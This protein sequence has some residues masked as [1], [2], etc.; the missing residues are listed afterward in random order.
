MIAAILFTISIATFCQFGIYY[1]RAS[2]RATAETPVSDRLKFAAGISTSSLGPRD[3]QSILKVHDLTPA[4]SGS[5]GTF[6]AIR[7][8]YRVVESLGRIIPSIT[9][10]AEAEMTVCTRY[11][12]VLVDQRLERNIACA[13]HVR[14]I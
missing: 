13:E 3:F 14:S 7:A 12:A 1:W 6:R 8:Y 9:G 4:L 10:W 5:G 2:V 11:M